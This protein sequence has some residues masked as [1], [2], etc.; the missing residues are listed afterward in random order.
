MAFNATLGHPRQTAFLAIDEVAAYLNG[1]LTTAWGD[2]TD[3]EKEEA[4]Q[5]VTE[6]VR[7]LRWIGDNHKFEYQA[8]PFPRDDINSLRSDTAATGSTTTSIVCASL[9]DDPWYDF[10]GGAVHIGTSNDVDYG[11][12]GR[13]TAFERSTGTLTVAGDFTEDTDGKFVYI[14]GPLPNMI[15]N[16]IAEQAAAWINR[17]DPYT[18][19]EAVHRGAT[20]TTGDPGTAATL[21]NVGGKVRWKARAYQMVAQWVTK[22]V[23][24]GRE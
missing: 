14:I 22:G 16:G 23:R 10:I 20:S 17:N 2:A 21:T 6:D 19:A 18:V 4:L 3:A 7:A 12:G 8:Q 1:D 15:R 13:I 5:R 24:T 9:T 11:R